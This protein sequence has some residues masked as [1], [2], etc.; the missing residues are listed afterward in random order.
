MWRPT[1]LNR[2]LKLFWQMLLAFTIT[3][4]I[5]ALGVYLSGLHAFRLVAEGFEANIPDDAQLW[6]ER[7]GAYY[8]PQDG[9]NGVSAMIASYPTG[10]AWAPWDTSWIPALAV[11]DADGR[12]LYSSLPRGSEPDLVEAIRDDR[13]V[14]PI[15]SDDEVVGYLW[16]PWFVPAE[17]SAL[18]VADGGPFSSGARRYDFLWAALKQFFAT[19]ALVIVVGLLLGATLSRRITRPLQDFA[20]ATTQIAGGDLSVRIG[21]R[22]P[23]ELGDL[24][25]SFNAMASELD[26]SDQLRRNMTA[27]VAHELRTPLSVIRG[28]LEGILDG[29][30]PATEEHII[31]ILEETE[32]LTHLVEDLR[33][34][35]L[36]EARQLSLDLRPTDVGHL[37]RDAQVNFSPLAEDRN[38]ALILDMPVGLPSVLGDRQRL[39][40]VLGN[41]ITNALRHTPSGG[42]VTLA[43]S[44]SDGDAVI[45]VRDT[46]A[47]IAAEDLDHVFGRFWRGEKS[48]SRESGGSGLGLA[49]ARELVLLHGGTIEVESTL[50]HGSMFRCRLPVGERGR[51]QQITN[52]R[53]QTA[54]HRRGLLRSRQPSW[55]RACSA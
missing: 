53:S 27:D 49:I 13:M 20:A 50:G 5:I 2:R 47:G 11:S 26:R 40:Q 35:A 51:R 18:G 4:T 6:A 55:G 43:G 37:L 31:P 9:W 54:S 32:V 16:R 23:G 52:G 8:D 42:T 17:T 25:V 39:S 7:L 19:E 12:L 1:D 33:V 15:E 41:L 48:R 29:V 28:K 34:L 30:Y 21:R 45:E 22:Y 38:V 44:A 36:A 46:G 14:T 24:A 3:M 10:D